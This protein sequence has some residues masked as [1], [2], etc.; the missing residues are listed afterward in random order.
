M[1]AAFDPERTYRLL[2]GDVDA[3]I[4]MVALI[5]QD[6]PLYVDRLRDQVEAGDWRGAAE[7]AHA[8]RG[9]VDNFGAAWLA[10]VARAVERGARTGHPDTVRALWPR[11]E[12]AASTLID[13]LH[14]WVATLRR[15][16]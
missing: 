1:T 7:T 8:V 10:D 5:D 16:S 6:L 13:A 14:E 11:F 15:A 12:T 3:I 4:E 9:A 2:D